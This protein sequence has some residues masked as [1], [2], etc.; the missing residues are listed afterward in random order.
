MSDLPANLPKSI[1]EGLKALSGRWGYFVVFGVALIALGAMA[2]GLVVSATLA[3]VF[4]IGVLMVLTGAAEIAIGF[5]AR[6]WGRLALWILSGVLYAAAGL[7]A[8][9]RPMMAAAV[10]TLM[11]GAGL[12]ASGA[13]RFFLSTHLPADGPRGLAMFSSAVTIIF[14]LVVLLGWP[15]DSGF[16][17]G[18]IL[19]VDLLFA[20]VGWL[21]LGLALRARNAG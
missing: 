11:L 19:A 1:E 21:G 6:D 12:I 17:L 13:L 9:S 18:T 4:A 14:G 16:V 20:G 15:G 2:A 5:H 3:S 7:I 8:I 10:F